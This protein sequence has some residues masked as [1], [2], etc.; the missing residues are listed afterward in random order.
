M[1]LQTAA[2]EGLQITFVVMAES[3]WTMEIPNELARWGRTFGTGM[4]E[5]RWDRLAEGLGCH[6]EFVDSLDA[7]PAALARARECAGPA[8]VCVRTS[9]EAN[10]SVPEAGI[11][12]FF[13]VYNGPSA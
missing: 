9:K 13:E 8:L 12:R 3:E 6:G 4:G 10:L 1:E 7:M 2:R 5:V 11:A